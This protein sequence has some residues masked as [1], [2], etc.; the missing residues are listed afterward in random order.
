[1]KETAYTARIGLKD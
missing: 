1:L